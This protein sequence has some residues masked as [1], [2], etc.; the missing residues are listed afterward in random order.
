MPDVTVAICTWNR[1]DLLRST[2]DGLT[3]LV[4]PDAVEWEVLVVN[5]RCT[6]HTDKVIEGFSAKIP[7]RRLYEPAQGHSRARNMAIQQARGKYVLWIDDDVLVHPDWLA[8]M[9]AAFRAHPDSVLLAGPVRPWFEIPPPDWVRS[10]QT[11]LSGVLVC[12][13]HGPEL[14]QLRP[15][16]SIFGANMAVRTDVAR[17]FLFNV[18]LG[19]EAESLVGGDD[20]D[21]RKRLAEVGHATLW[22]PTAPV[23][24]FVPAARLTK[25]YV[26]RWYRDAGRTYVR[27][28]GIERSW[29]LAGVP[30]WV[31]RRYVTK[32]LGRFYWAAFSSARWFRAFRE[33]LILEGIIRETW[34]SH[35][36]STGAG[37]ETPPSL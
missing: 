36:L 10:L 16:E 11:E 15:D 31:L 22:V 27:R 19:R 29:R 7:V 13:D 28:Y 34:R 12:V 20:T 4:I 5:N 25:T 24:H 18:H 2:L 35:R 6:D 9:L 14:R 26:R 8:G 37:P 33:S 30:G 32:N 23:D 3:R 17:T 21:F 1:A